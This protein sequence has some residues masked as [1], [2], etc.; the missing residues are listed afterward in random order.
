VRRYPV[1]GR[2]VAA[3]RPFPRG[4]AVLEYTGELVSGEEA[5]RREMEV[6]SNF[7]LFFRFGGVAYW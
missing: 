5:R 3:T 2:G 1:K 7:L 4:T 6:P